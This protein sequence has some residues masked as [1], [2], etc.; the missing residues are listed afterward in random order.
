MAANADSLHSSRE[1]LET[2]LAEVNALALRLRQVSVPG[3]TGQ[4]PH[5]A[6][7]VLQFLERQGP[8]TVPALARARGTSRQN[9]QTIV[10]RLARAGFAGTAQNPAHKRSELVCITEAGAA[11][12]QSDSLLHAEM[13]DRLLAFASDAELVSA[14]ELIHRLSQELDRERP[15]SRTAKAK[16]SGRNISPERPNPQFQNLE[17]ELPVSLL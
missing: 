17:P 11:I 16:Q 9:I 6:R 4:I 7:A 12:L 13:L 2:F 14:S 10:N 3:R 1:Q 15:R 8:A 5:A